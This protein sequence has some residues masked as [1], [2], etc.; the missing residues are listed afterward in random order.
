VVDRAEKPSPN[1][2]GITEDRRLR[3]EFEV[4]EIKPDPDHN[5]CSN[6]RI[7]PGGRVR[8][9]MTLL[10][11]ILETQG[12]TNTHRVVGGP[13][14]IDD[15]CFV[16]QAKGPAQAEAPAG[17]NGPVWNGMDVDSMRSMLRALLEDRFQLK[18]HTEERPVSGYALVPAKAKLRKADLSN[19]PGC[20][21][22]PGP[23][24]KDPR[25]TNPLASRLVTCR[26]MT[27]AQFATELTKMGC[28]CGPVVDATQITGRYDLTVNF[29]PPTAFP[30]PGES[31]AGPDTASDPTGAISIFDALPKQLG[32]RLQAREVPTP[33]LVIDHIDDKPTEN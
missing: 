19:R 4:A 31:A 14:S 29:S 25:L 13:K 22:G 32:L 10:G 15:H 11:L 5:E 28:G 9:N 1:P 23:D 16:V 24:G 30:K 27:L 3:P 18:A 33:V 21:E 2:R 26:N 6:V 7:D 12:E 17:W 8:I 20:K